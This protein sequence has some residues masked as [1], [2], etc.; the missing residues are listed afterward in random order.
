MKFF[1]EVFVTLLVITDPAGTVPLF[2]ALTRGREPRERHRLAWQAA[3]VAFGVILA[4]ALFGR[5]VLTYLGVEL[6][7]LQA[8]GGLLL[9]LVALELLTGKSAEPTEAERERINVAF[10]PLG[11]PLL[12]GPGA[13]VAS[14]LFVQRIH[15]GAQVAAFGLALCAVIVVLWLAMRFCGLVK[16]ILRDSGVELLTRISGLLLSA[17]AVQLVADAVRA[18]VK[19]G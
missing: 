7:A 3:L 12:A 11:T 6:P 5:E 9:L 19:Q 2:I 8:A 18:F 13:I 10:V 1:W 4:F 16:R 14:M 15:N 17:I